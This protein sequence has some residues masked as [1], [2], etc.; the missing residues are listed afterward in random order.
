MLRALGVVVLTALVAGTALAPD[1]RAQS[2]LLDQGRNLLGMPSPSQPARPAAG[3]SLTN[4]DMIGGL[5][6]AL[7]VGTERTTGRLGKPD[8]YLK[9]KDVHIPLPGALGQVQQALKLAGA[10]ALMDDLET[11]MNRAAEAAAPKAAGIFGTAIGNMSI[12]DARSILNG[13]KDAATQY[14]KRETT[15]PLS[16]AMKPV[17]E[18]SLSDVGAVN[19]LKSVGDK[20]RSLP[21]GGAVNFDLTGYVLEQALA[22]LFFYLAK[23]E[24]AIRDNPAQRSTELLK[25]VFGG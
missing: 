7:K 10:S 15:K 16:E 4:N 9:D 3:G 25:K 23:E 2:S 13:P 5:K 11:R 17:V 19:S 6:D 1:S 20:Y 18:R 8:G 24:A 22:G 21:L 14:F 12:G